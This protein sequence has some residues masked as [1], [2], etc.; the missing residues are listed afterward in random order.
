MHSF[1]L[2]GSIVNG[3]WGAWSEWTKCPVTCGGDI[4]MGTRLCDNPPSHLG[5]KNCTADGSNNIETKKCNENECP[6]K[7]F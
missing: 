3:G 6:G 4:Q 7:H 1:Y 2:E 5:G